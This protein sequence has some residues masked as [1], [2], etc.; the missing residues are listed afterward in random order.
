MLLF[1]IEGQVGVGVGG[2][3]ESTPSQTQNCRFAH[4]IFPDWNLGKLLTYNQFFLIYCDVLRQCDGVCGVKI[5]DL[6][7]PKNC[8]LVIMFK[9]FAPLISVL[10]F[11]ASDST[12]LLHWWLFTVSHQEVFVNQWKGLD[13]CVTGEGFI[14]MAMYLEQPRWFLVLV[15]P[16]VS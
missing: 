12:S 3:G 2:M 14:T 10:H 1:L 6:V 9:E 16:F 8:F 7:G 5:T 11:R 15:S 4:P 13:N